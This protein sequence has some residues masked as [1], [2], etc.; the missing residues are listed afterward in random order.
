MVCTNTQKEKR[1]HRAKV[2]KFFAR[3]S[4]RDRSL[5]NLNMCR[6]SQNKFTSVFSVIKTQI[7]HKQSSSENLLNS[8]QSINL[9][10]PQAFSSSFDLSK[11]A[12]SQNIHH[13]SS[14]TSAPDALF[15]DI[16]MNQLTASTLPYPLF[17]RFNVIIH[18]TANRFRSVSIHDIN[19]EA[20][21]TQQAS[22]ICLNA[23]IMTIPPFTSSAET[24]DINTF[25]MNQF[26][27]LKSPSF[28]SLT[29]NQLIGNLNNINNNI[30]MLPALDTQNINKL[31]FTFINL[32]NR[33]SQ[34]LR[35]QIAESVLYELRSS[36]PINSEIVLQQLAMLEANQYHLFTHIVRFIYKPRC[37]EL[38]SKY[39]AKIIVPDI[40]LEKVNLSQNQFPKTQMW[41]AMKL[42]AVSKKKRYSHESK[43]GI[44]DD[45]SIP[46]WTFICI[47]EDKN[48]AINASFIVHIN[49][50]DLHLY[51]METIEH[52]F[53]EYIHKVQFLI[54][55]Q[56][57]LQQLNENK[58][59]S[60]FLIA[61]QKET[62]EEQSHAIDSL[63]ILIIL[64]V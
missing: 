9:V 12:Q 34:R 40:K 41:F 3:K 6:K 54:N 11:P 19:D 63:V 49:P 15:E 33:F 8:P 61:P 45:C 29:E 4:S 30:N 50:N 7:L 18:G 21:Y 57:L 46:Y 17:I 42:N 26:D 59:V 20:I 47:S 24:D 52:R 32:Y 28:V 60:R 48:N 16:D 38:L 5:P 35:A 36:K 31:P 25:S 14:T 51:K 55:Q 23:I 27:Q 39:M 13:R 58:M 53:R 44:Y 37:F 22:A 43:E 56:A 2:S 10:P 62:D 64:I 1:M